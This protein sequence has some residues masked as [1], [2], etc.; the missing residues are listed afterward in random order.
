MDKLVSAIRYVGLKPNIDEYEWRFRIQKLAFI[1]EVLGFG[2]E[3]KFFLHK[4][5][6]WSPDLNKAYYDQKSVYESDEKAFELKDDDIRT[7]DRVKES[8]DFVFSPHQVIEGTATA[9]FLYE[10]AGNKID[11]SELSEKLKQKKSHL[12]NSDIVLSINNMKK[13]LFKD[14]YLTSDIKKEISEWESVGL[15]SISE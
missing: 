7:L 2:I 15:K 6:P 11:D 13:L 3:Y 5:G 10:N 1:L 8:I 4:E 14:E 12:S 9:L